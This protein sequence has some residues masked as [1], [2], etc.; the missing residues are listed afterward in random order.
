MMIDLSA[1]F[2]MVDHSLLLD[3]LA[4]FGIDAEVTQ[5]LGSYLTGRSQSVLVDDPHC[6]DCGSTVCYVDDATFSVS[7]SDPGILSQKLSNQ[8]KKIE[9]YMAANKLVINGDKTH[10]VVMGSL[11]T[12]PKDKK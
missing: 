1:A 6:S 12:Q 7:H 4:L 9:E 5:W 3:K 2:D 10:L 8:Y 11:L